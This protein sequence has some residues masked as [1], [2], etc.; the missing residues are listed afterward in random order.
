MHNHNGFSD[1]S[2]DD[3]AKIH[4]AMIPDND[5]T[6]LAQTRARSQAK[7]LANGDAHIAATADWTWATKPVVSQG[8]CGSCWAFTANTVLEGTRYIYESQQ[9]AS[10]SRVEYSHQ[11][12][13]SCIGTWGP[14]YWTDGCDGGT[15][16]G[17]WNWYK[18]NGTLT[19][20]QYP[21]TSGANG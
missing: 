14:P 8:G 10:V 19:T 7:G 9:D 21:Y 13:V 5:G 20:S 1:M 12:P 3:M 16:I 15:V 17:A 11:L 4:G 2:H 6:D 18:D